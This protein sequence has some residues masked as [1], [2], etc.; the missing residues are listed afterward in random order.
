MRLK[1]KRKETA[2]RRREEAAY[3][4]S[5]TSEAR[6]RA[7]YRSSHPKNYKGEKRG[8][9][10]MRL[11]ARFVPERLSNGD[12]MLDL[13]TRSKRLLAQSGDK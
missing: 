11:N 2:K 3:N 7:R 12:T 6:R 9:K 1:L 13:L 5:G 10:P 4:A 8:R